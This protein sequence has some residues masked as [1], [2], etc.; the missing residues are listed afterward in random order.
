MIRTEKLRFSISIS[1]L[2]IGWFVAICNFVDLNGHYLN[3][4]ATYL[5]TRDTY[6]MTMS[7]KYVSDYLKVPDG[8]FLF[9]KM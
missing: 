5:L 2:P 1:Y 9:S 3:L 8:F 4:Q 6:F 7:S